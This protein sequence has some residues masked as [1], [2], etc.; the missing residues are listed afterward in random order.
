M[1]YRVGIKGST[2]GCGGYPVVEEGGKVVGCHATRAQADEHIQALYAN[3]P[4]A[5][6]SEV[7]GANPS[8]TVDPK[9]PGVGIKRPD[10]GRRGGT[11]GSSGLRSKPAP[12]PKQTRRG[13]HSDAATSATGAT[14][15]GG[16]GGSIA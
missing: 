15:S 14:S 1:P 2:P 3:V 16:P 4:D 8:F 6:K 10:Q 9:Y 13:C 12:K 5:S 11:P 7:A